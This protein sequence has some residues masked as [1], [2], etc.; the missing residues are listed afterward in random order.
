MY[1]VG[2]VLLGGYKGKQSV[3]LGPILTQDIHHLIK[4]VEKLEKKYN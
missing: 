2:R 1:I 3:F 4:I